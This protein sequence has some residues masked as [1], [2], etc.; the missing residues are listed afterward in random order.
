MANLVARSA[1]GFHKLLPIRS[2]LNAAVVFA[3][4]GADSTLVPAIIHESLKINWGVSWFIA[5]CPVVV[6][7][8]KEVTDAS[9]FQACCFRQHAG[10]DLHQQ[11]WQCWNNPANATTILEMP[12]EDRH[13]V[14]GRVPQVSDWLRVWRAV[15][16][17][18]CSLRALEQ[19][20]F[21][22]SHL[23]ISG[24]FIQC[25]FGLKEKVSDIIVQLSRW[26]T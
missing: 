12:D 24:N 20:S 11:A 15:K 19:I 5:T 17:T 3:R 9:C 7:Q 22:D 2:P 13:L 6:R 16:S 4:S 25:R 10:T 23:S 8:R 1:L 26:V 21:T 14:R 18:S